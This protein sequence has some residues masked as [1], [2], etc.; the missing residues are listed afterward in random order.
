MQIR[1][2]S[3]AHLKQPTTVASIISKLNR[4]RILLVDFKRRN[5][6]PTLGFEPLIFWLVSEHEFPN[7]SPIHQ[8]EAF[9]LRGTF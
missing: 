8:L 6:F 2:K 4:K 5:P 3:A 1:G 9:L 7:I